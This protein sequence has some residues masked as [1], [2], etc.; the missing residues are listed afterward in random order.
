MTPV[1]VKPPI[2]EMLRNDTMTDKQW[3]AE[4]HPDLRSY[5]YY[6]PVFGCIGISHPLEHDP[7]AGGMSPA[8]INWRYAAMQAQA[9]Q[10][11]KERDWSSYIFTHSKPYRVGAFMDVMDDMTDRE[12][13]SELAAVWIG[14]ENTHQNHWDWRRLF[15][16]TRGER[17]YFMN[18]G[19]R[20][21]FAA[22]REKITIYRGHHR[23][24]KVGWAWTLSE[25]KA[26]FFANRL[27][28]RLKGGKIREITINKSD[29]IGYLNGR[30]EQEIVLARAR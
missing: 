12:Y 27:G 17:E 10:A 2:E 6:P 16:S 4:L 22:L 20:E 23:G 1:K 19:E 21:F 28:A 13:W 11:I 8:V 5:V 14:S 7:G 29:A 15:A 26:K 3:I 9:A 25:E 24:N 30:E 18:A